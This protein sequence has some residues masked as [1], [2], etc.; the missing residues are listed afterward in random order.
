MSAS[1]VKARTSPLMDAIWYGP[2]QPIPTEDRGVTLP[3][4]RSSKIPPLPDSSCLVAQRRPTLGLGAWDP[5]VPPP[6]RDTGTLPTFSPLSSDTSRGNTRWSRGARSPERRAAPSADHGAAARPSASP[7]GRLDPLA[8]QR[9]LGY[10]GPHS[11]G[12]H[13]TSSHRPR[14]RGPQG[15]HA[16]RCRIG[17]HAP[18]LRMVG[19]QQRSRTACGELSDKHLD[20]SSSN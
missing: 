18:S 13:P 7:G 19:F 16:P 8:A 6:G 10:L 17:G 1:T 12:A 20:A 3:R 14:R 11:H 5:W 4:S 9:I 15:T 2:G